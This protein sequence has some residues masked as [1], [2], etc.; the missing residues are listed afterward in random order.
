MA[1]PGEG[2][3]GRTWQGNR[4]WGL[5]CVQRVHGSETAGVEGTH[6]S[7]P[8]PIRSQPP[9]T[10]STPQKRQAS[11]DMRTPHPPV[12]SLPRLLATVSQSTAP[13]TG[14]WAVKPHSSGAPPQIATWKST[15]ICFNSIY[16][17]W[18]TGGIA[19]LEI[20]AQGSRQPLCLEF[21]SRQS[22][23]YLQRVYRQGSCFSQETNNHKHTVCDPSRSKHQE[24]FTNIK[25]PGGRICS[26][27][28]GWI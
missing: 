19:A 16:R 13:L 7:F 1:G 4:R 10:A 23:V 6:L 27:R 28:A 3:P 2:L 11:K 24:A 5:V 26:L 17:I 21:W 15:Y 22:W 8:A 12:T 20:P 25:H 18:G 9:P 14:Q